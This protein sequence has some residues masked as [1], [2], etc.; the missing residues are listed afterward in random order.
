MDWFFFNKY[1]LV[2]LIC[3]DVG[4]GIGEQSCFLVYYYVQVVGL[5]VLE[6]VLEIVRQNDDFN[7]LYFC[8]FDICDKVNVV[9]FY[10]E[11][12]DCNFYI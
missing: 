12:G 6:I 9:I 8:Y 11:F 7:K 1:F 2:E 3:L 4:C 10:Q 5:E